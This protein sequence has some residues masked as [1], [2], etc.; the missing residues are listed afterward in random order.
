MGLLGKWGTA[1]VPFATFLPSRVPGV[2]SWRRGSC[3]G[4]WLSPGRRH[5]GTRQERRQLLRRGGRSFCPS[6]FFPLCLAACLPKEK[7]FMGCSSVCPCLFVPPLPAVLGS[8]RCQPSVSEGRRAERSRALAFLCAAMARGTTGPLPAPILQGAFFVLR[9]YRA[10]LGAGGF[11]RSHA[12]HPRPGRCCRWV[13]GWCEGGGLIPVGPTRARST[14]PHCLPQGGTR[15]ARWHCHPPSHRWAC[16]GACPAAAGELQHPPAV[17]SS[18]YCRWSALC[19]RELQ[20]CSKSPNAQRFG[21]FVRVGNVKNPPVIN[22]V[23]RTRLRRGGEFVL[24][25]HPPTPGTGEERG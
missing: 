10:W 22:V 23:P 7:H 13:W 5:P 24:R 21:A 9:Q 8:G 18:C 11:G 4:G 20:L 19:V 25:L 16:P 3:R 12:S 6:S 1:R 14:R 2:C 15:P 17:A